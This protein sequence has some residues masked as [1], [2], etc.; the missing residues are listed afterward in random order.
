[1]HNQAR[2]NGGVSTRC[3]NTSII[4]KLGDHLLDVF[5]VDFEVAAAFL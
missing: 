1:M 3:R 4:L 2:I 5:G